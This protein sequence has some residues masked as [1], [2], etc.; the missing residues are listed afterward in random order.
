MSPEAAAHS[1][2]GF[3]RLASLGVAW[4]AVL[5]ACGGAAAPSAAPTSSPASPSAAAPSS[6]PASAKPA[7][8]T[9]ASAKPAGSAAASAKPAASGAA[10]AKPAASPAASGGGNQAVFN[11]AYPTNGGTHAPLWIAE[12]AGAF[13]DN[14]LN[15]QS[16]YI[17]GDI[18][19]KALIGKD[20][21]VVL[22]SPASAITAD[23]NANLD[24]VYVGSVLNHSQFSLMTI[25]TI[26]TAADLKGKNVGTDK[27]GTTGDYQIRL[28]LDILKLQP[29]DVQLRVLGG[30]DIVAPALASK[31]IDAAPLIP[32]YSFKAEDA[33]FTEL[34]NTF[35]SPYQNVGVTVPK[36]RIDAMSDQLH[37][38]LLGY[39]KGVQLFFTNPDLAKKILTD[40]AK[41]T[42]PQELQR[43]YDFYIKQAPFQLDL[44]PTLEGIQ[45]MLDF[46]GST[47]LPAAKNAKPEQFVDNRFLA[48]LPKLTV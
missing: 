1:R 36:S 12:E 48:D 45:A 8:S 2:R 11:V 46:L 47:I 26:K 6:A 21:D 5:A 38:F 7:G 40:K 31:Q 39:Q 44:K 13:K 28:L 29:S 37:K 16:Q 27:P 34:A 32:P 30:S 23:L 10:S 42:D 9:A 20:V 22:Q 17:A 18:A 24:I 41:I 4:G 25:P 3:L 15:V 19:T 35:K 33:G 14:G 43:T